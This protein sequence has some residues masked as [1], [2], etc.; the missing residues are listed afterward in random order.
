MNLDRSLAAEYLGLKKKTLDNWRCCGRGPRY[1]KLGARVLY[2]QSELDAF[3]AAN[4]RTSTAQNG[5]AA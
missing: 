3:K 4:L 2:P 1:L 5:R